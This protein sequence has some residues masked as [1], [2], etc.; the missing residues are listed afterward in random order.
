MAK[1]IS[2]DDSMYAFTCI[3]FLIFTVS[4]FSTLSFF[5]ILFFRGSTCG[6]PGVGVCVAGTMDIS[7][8]LISKQ[9]IH[10]D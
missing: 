5:C 3:Y 1:S 10:G 8:D 6:G 7:F 4:Y 2:G 9:I